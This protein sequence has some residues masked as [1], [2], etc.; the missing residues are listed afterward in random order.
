MEEFLF[1]LYKNLGCRFDKNFHL[2]FL[3]WHRWLHVDVVDSSVF[4][5]EKRGKDEILKQWGIETVR[6]CTNLLGFQH[7]VETNIYT[8]EVT[9]AGPGLRSRSPLVNKWDHPGP[10]FFRGGH[11]GDHPGPG[12]FGGG[13]I[14]DH[15]RP[16]F[17]GGGGC[18]RHKKW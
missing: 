3:W 10:G 14:R 17:W 7:P 2:H 4:K 12:F 6:K 8:G 18:H 9:G 13:H 1:L 5:Q 11:I 16:G 15:P